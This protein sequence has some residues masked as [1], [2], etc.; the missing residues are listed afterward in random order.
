[1]ESLSVSSISSNAPSKIARLMDELLT[2][3]GAVF[4][5]VSDEL[6]KELNSLGFTKEQRDV[7][8]TVAERSLHT[9]AER[10]RRL[11]LEGQ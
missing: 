4:L 6:L 7:V 1:M 10:A 5:E 2:A 9:G 11:S 3:R 8:F